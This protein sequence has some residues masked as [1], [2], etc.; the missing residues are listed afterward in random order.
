MNTNQNDTVI[1]AT[2]PDPIQLQ[3]SHLLEVIADELAYRANL[4]RIHR[5]T[6]IRAR[7]AKAAQDEL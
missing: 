6:A 1:K 5:D 2:A 4:K 3:A 7:L